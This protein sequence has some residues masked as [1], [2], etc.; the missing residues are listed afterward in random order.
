MEQ[1]D[2]FSV[3]S[4][5]ILCL[6]PILKEEDIP[7]F[8]EF[9]Q[10]IPALFQLLNQCDEYDQALK[11]TLDKAEPLNS[12]LIATCFKL[13]N[14]KINA[15]LAFLLTQ[16]TQTQLKTQTLTFGA[17]QL[18]FLS[19]TDWALHQTVRIQLLLQ[20]PACAIYGYATVIET[21]QTADDLFRITLRYLHLQE[22]DRDLLIRAALH[23]Q[24]ALL[25]QRTQQ[26]NKQNP[27]S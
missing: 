20:T 3:N 6:D 8:A 12:E 27:N 15:L 23:I 17:S 26:H 14:T 5:Q 22:S 13:Q 25:R 18:S 19:P 21:H 24:Q 9:L 2:Y 16:H 1:D 7:S 10:E 4:Q 11:K